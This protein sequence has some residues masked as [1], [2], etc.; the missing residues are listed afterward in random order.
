MIFATQGAP[1]HDSRMLVDA[2]LTGRVR[3]ARPTA[4]AG[5]P[6]GSWPSPAASPGRAGRRA[7]RAARRAPGCAR[8]RRAAAPRGRRRVEPRARAAAPAGSRARPRRPPLAARHLDGLGG[9]P[10]DFAPGAP[11]RQRHLSGR[12]ARRAR[13]PRRRM[14]RAMA[15]AGAAVGVEPPSGSAVRDPGMEIIPYGGW[16]RARAPRL[17]RHGARRHARHRPA[18]HPVRRHRRSERVLRDPRGHGRDRRDQVQVLRRSPALDRPRGRAADVAARQRSG[19]A[20]GGERRARAP[21]RA[22][23]VRNA[24]GGPHRGGRARAGS[25]SIMRSR[26]TALMRSS[27][28]RGRFSVM[29]GGGECLFPQAPFVPHPDRVLPARPLVRGRTPTWPSRGG[30]GASA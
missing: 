5:A 3:S 22:G 19:G 23:Q 27:S 15:W 10:A 13:R 4:S 8:P 21:D 16:K 26:T 29:A 18:H 28:P 20:P 14:S 24:E 25:S 30:H 7:R 1:D 17:R 12:A 6:S 2:L 11:R 9:R